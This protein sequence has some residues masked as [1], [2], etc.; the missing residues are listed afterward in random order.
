MK[1]EIEIKARVKDKEALI[2]FL[3][4][5]AKYTKKYFKKDIYYAK[6]DLIEKKYFDINECLRL[7]IERGRYTFCTKIRTLIDSVEV[8]TEIEYVVS[9]R[10]SK[11]VLK[12][13]GFLFGYKEFVKKEKKGRAFLYKNTLI[14]VSSIKKLGDF[15]EI[16]LLD[17]LLPREEQVKYLKTVL[18]E[19]G[20][21]ENDIDDTPY[22]VYLCRLL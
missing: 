2:D 14:E 10:E 4:K 8:N 17:S 21:T 20:L 16:E 9:K 22:I 19:I 1:M 11:R 7:R 15:V 3:F 18:T 5:N 13:L 12:F 6:A